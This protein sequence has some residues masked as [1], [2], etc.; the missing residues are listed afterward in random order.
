LAS[1]RRPG[2]DGDGDLVQAAAAGDEGAFAALVTRHR[3]L[4]WSVCHRICTDPHVAEDAFQLTL[5]AVWR[6]LARFDGR[7]RFSTWLY[8]IAV[9]ASLGVLRARRRERTVALDDH[10]GPTSVRDPATAVADADAV[11]WALARL[12]F[13]F[14]CAVVLRDLCGCSYQEVAD[15]AGVKVD[16]AKTRIARGRQALAALLGPTATGGDR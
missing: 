5:I 10:P 4:L 1:A 2:G 12:P 11:Q 9:N 15:I 6:G 8:R 3:D 14:R 7:A 16:T 13:D